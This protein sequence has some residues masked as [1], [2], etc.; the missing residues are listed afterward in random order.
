[1]KLCL[2][3]VEHD[4]LVLT[5]KYSQSNLY[6]ILKGIR[7]KNRWRLTVLTCRVCTSFFFYFQPTLTKR[8]IES[9]LYSEENKVEK[10][11]GEVWQFCRDVSVRRFF[12]LST[13]LDQEIHKVKRGQSLTFTAISYKPNYLREKN[14]IYPYEKYQYSEIRLLKICIASEV[15]SWRLLIG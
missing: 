4:R 11:T 5:I 9:M 12:L 7:L 2:L 8:S 14:D 3:I 15:S 13:H 1:M 10:S 6:F